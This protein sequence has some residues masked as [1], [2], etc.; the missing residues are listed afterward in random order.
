M[1]L[2]APTIQ[3][4]GTS[5]HPD[6]LR[7]D[8]AFFNQGGFQSFTMTGTGSTAGGV[9]NSNPAIVIT[10]GIII[11]PVLS[12]RQANVGIQNG[13]S[14][15]T[16]A[17]VQLPEGYRNTV[18]L[19]FRAPGVLDSSSSELKV[20]GRIDMGAGSL[21]T[22]DALGKVT[23]HGQTVHMAG[24][25]V[26]PGGAVLIHGASHYPE[27]SPSNVA[28]STVFLTSSASISTAG[29]TVYTFSTFGRRTGTVHAGGSI[30]IEG[31]LIAN[32][33]TLLDVSGTSAVLD[34]TPAQAGNPIGSI[35]SVTEWFQPSE[36]APTLVMSNAGSISLKGGDFLFSRATLL[37]QAGGAQAQGGTLNID[38][39]RFYIPGGLKDDRDISLIVSQDI[40]AFTT[41]AVALGQ[42]L[43]IAALGYFGA[44]TFQNGGFDSLH[45]AGNVE[46][47]GAVALNGRGA[48]SIADN[49]VIQADALTTLTA[50]Y[51]K[52]G[53]TLNQPIRDEELVNPY[54]KDNPLGGGRIF[55]EFNPTTGGG[56]LVVNADLV[57]V[58]FLS[59]QGIDSA[60]ITARHELR[61]AGYLDIAG[62]LDLTVGQ[63]VPNTAST[64]AI[65]AYNG[66]AVTIASSGITPQFPLSAGGRLNI[67]AQT[68][69][70]SGVLRAPFGSIRLGWDGTGTA[71]RGLVTNSPVPVTQQITLAAGSST[72]VSGIDPHTD[73][74]VV[75]PYGLL[76]DGTNW[77]D[78][79]GLDITATGVPEKSLRV[80]AQNVTTEAGSTLDI[81][82][83][84][85]L[86]A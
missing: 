69:T 78:P 85:E 35:G 43:G 5:V 21:I 68:I 33:G 59:L 14:L 23:L 79:T 86:Y 75:I 71:P 66:G 2:L 84:G 74:G 82:G 40:N 27:N 17:T 10:P 16:L 47:R 58:G 62:N 81:R 25:I 46:F 61:G 57:D 3:V 67:F 28:L 80:S 42:A 7:L 52:L 36:L 56:R 34:L 1:S 39:G 51:V 70:Q 11:A 8:P 20:R 44:N 38:S 13:Q 55:S 15:I 83:G 9:D 64:F 18:S 41:S 45:L 22:T 4:G 65:T 50:S 48:M 30:T 31:N 19:D 12:S 24:N 32:T 60:A 26:A 73:T 37:G 49:G 29:K 53:L 6:T 76:K 54:M 72:S 63:I 77:I